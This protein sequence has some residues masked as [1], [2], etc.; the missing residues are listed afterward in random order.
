MNLTCRTPSEVGPQF[1]RVLGDHTGL[2]RELQLRRPGR[3]DPAVFVAQPQESALSSLLENGAQFSLDAAGKGLTREASLRSAIGETLERY[4]LYW[5]PRDGLVEGSYQALIDDG[6]SVP[7]FEYLD[8]PSQRAVTEFG[9]DRFRR[10]TVI[11]WAQ[12]TDLL[13]GAPASVP[14]QQVWLGIDRGEEYPHCFESTS[15]GCA[16]ARSRRASLVGAISE[17]VERDAFVRTWYGGTSPDRLRL[18]SF[19]TLERLREERLESATLRFQP[20]ALESPVSVQ[21]VGC[22]ASDTRNRTPKFVLGTAAA[23]D[24]ETALRDAM[25]EAAQGWPYVQALT[26]GTDERV[27]PDTVTDFE[28]NVRYYA[29]ARHFDEVEHLLEGDEVAP[30]PEG[31]CESSQVPL[32]RWLRRLENAGMR[33]IAFDVTTRD[34]RRLGVRVTRVRIPDLLSLPLPSL[35]H[36]GHPAF[37]DGHRRMHPLP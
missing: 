18:D 3:T 33:P 22:V 8:V 21:T 36:T 31:D 35:P 17:A 14:A 19:P 6:E 9:R 4:C 5:P 30:S 32:V 20:I 10:D 34:V 7:A 13:T 1:E 2:V 16:A 12:G 25:I 11:Q 27:D 37:P 15:N 28:D 24:L 23:L 26:T 29:K